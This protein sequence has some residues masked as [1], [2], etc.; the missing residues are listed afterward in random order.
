MTSPIPSSPEAFFTTY[1]PERIAKLSAALA[2]RSSPGS[3]LFDIPGV[4]SWS[5]SLA[6]GSLVVATG[7][8]PDR[9]LTIAIRPEDFEPIIVKGAEQA[10]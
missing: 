3:V 6:Q 7:A 10:E 5:L 8:Q 4:G 2:G 1:V 9:L